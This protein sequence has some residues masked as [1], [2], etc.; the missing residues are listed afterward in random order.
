MKRE[1]IFVR[2]KIDFS[3][4]LLSFDSEEYFPINTEN[5]HL[6]TFSTFCLF[7]ERIKLSTNHFFGK[8]MFKSIL[9]KTW[10][11][12]LKLNKIELISSY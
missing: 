8:L 11:F 12:C 2:E 3:S 10:I 4:I 9:I 7:L 5:I 6:N 1:S